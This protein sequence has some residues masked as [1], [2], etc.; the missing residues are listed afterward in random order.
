MYPVRINNPKSWTRYSLK[1]LF[2]GG[3]PI[4]C[5]ISATSQ[6]SVSISHPTTRR[7]KYPLQRFTIFTEYPF[8]IIHA[9]SHLKLDNTYIVYPSIEG[10]EALPATLSGQNAEKTGLSHDGDNDFSGLRE[11][12]KGESLA[13]IHWKL[14]AQDRGEFTKQFSQQLQSELS[15]DWRSLP[16]LD[17]E[18]KLSQLCRWIIDADANGLRYSLWLPTMSIASGSGELH[19]KHCLEALALYNGQ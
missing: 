5:D 8:G 6:H 16:H 14:V 7:G 18:A 13:H 17:Y 15:F 4:E 10:T 12:Q 3:D 19:K 9:W 1:L 2:T 11:Y